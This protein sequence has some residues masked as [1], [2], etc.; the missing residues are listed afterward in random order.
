MLAWINQRISHLHIP[1]SH[2]GTLRMIS[3]KNG[4]VMIGLVVLDLNLLYNFYTHKK[5]FKQKLAIKVRGCN[6]S[7]ATVESLEARLL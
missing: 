6:P 4:Y 3:A 7:W 1:L 5:I 2:S